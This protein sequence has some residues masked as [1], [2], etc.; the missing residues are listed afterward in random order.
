MFFASLRGLS[1]PHWRMLRTGRCFASAHSF[2]R[3]FCC[4]VEKSDR[5]ACSTRYLYRCKVSFECK[6]IFWDRSMTSLTSSYNSQSP[7]WWHSTDTESEL[8]TYAGP[9]FHW[10]PWRTWYVQWFRRS[11]L[12]TSAHPAKSLFHKVCFWSN[13]HLQIGP[14]DVPAVQL[15]TT[16]CYELQVSLPE[17]TS[18]WRF[19]SS[20]VAPD[21]VNDHIDHLRCLEMQI[22]CAGS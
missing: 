2:S 6:G 12:A 16:T 5:F 13:M 15:L 21:R 9:V 17:P 11:T 10:Y 4:F 1:C 20:Q 19:E 22:L 8:G 3:N 14:E 18:R 7:Q